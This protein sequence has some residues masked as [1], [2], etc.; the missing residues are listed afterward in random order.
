MKEQC[1]IVIVYV[2][3]NFQVP[4]VLISLIDLDR[5]W[6]KA[7]I[8]LPSRTELSRKG[9]LCNRVLMEDSP[10]V[11]ATE[12][13][14]KDRR[15]AHCDL[16][17][18]APNISP[19]DP[20]SSSENINNPSSVR[21]YASVAL[22]VSGM[23][24]GTLSMYD[25]VPRGDLVEKAACFLPDFGA[26]ISD[27]MSRRH[28]L[29]LGAGSEL[30]ELSLSVM[31][32]LKF[33]LIG[34]AQSLSALQSC[35]A[36]QPTKR[37]TKVPVTELA[38]NTSTCTATAGAGFV[39]L[40]SIDSAEHDDMSCNSGGRS[41]S[42]SRSFS[43]PT[44][45]IAAQ[46]KITTATTSAAA[47][48]SPDSRPSPAVVSP[49]SPPDGASVTPSAGSSAIIST[50]GSNK[51]TPPNTKI[52]YRKVVNS[53]ALLA[54]QDKLVEA[55]RDFLRRAKVLIKLLESSRSLA[56]SLQA[57]YL[58]HQ[59]CFGTVPSTPHSAAKKPRED[60]A[61]EK[62]YSSVRVTK[63]LRRLYANYIKSDLCAQELTLSVDPVLAPCPENESR[64]YQ[65]N[66][67]EYTSYG[68]S[69]KDGDVHHY[70]PRLPVIPQNPTRYRDTV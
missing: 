40:E 39:R 41:Q 18:I 42:H 68:E 60:A 27:A 30:S 1:F 56:H 26:I 59:Q 7:K 8:G 52:K 33:P 29:L 20:N 14:R 5:Q 9:A 38:I 58:R 31:Y 32:N 35:V 4:V 64:K 55:M 43:L 46:T 37:V 66:N 51:N 6:F 50:Q 17:W 57:Q 19:S 34:M 16:D 70:V 2:N 48:S 25:T 23:K 47:V 11:I 24:I 45:P 12:D 22:V 28:K 65:F 13:V 49:S 21:F 36:F 53:D 62:C 10:M 15:F 63:R 3:L 44:S 67:K 61:R 54:E 69:F